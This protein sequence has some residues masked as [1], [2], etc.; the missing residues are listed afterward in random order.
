MSH[1]GVRILEEGHAAQLV[2][3]S[4]WLVALLRLES[5]ERNES[6]CS[7]HQSLSHHNS[8]AS[9]RF[10]RPW[11]VS[12]QYLYLT[13]HL[14][15]EASF[16]W[17]YYTLSLA[18]PKILNLCSHLY[19]EN[20]F[21]D[22]K[23]R[24]PQHALVSADEYS[25]QEI[26]TTIPNI[27]TDTYKFKRQPLCVRRCIRESSTR[28]GMRLS[29]SRIYSAVPLQ[30]SEDRTALLLPTIIVWECPRRRESV[31]TA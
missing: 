20:I 15:R 23:V 27:A 31:R 28:A 25:V 30:F 2:L 22:F 4:I 8:W 14:L 21:F 26:S 18:S 6:R 10:S 29:R 9:S 11:E 7:R 16:G 3:A 5:V 1:S 17:Y 24:F 19:Q 13:F 12:A